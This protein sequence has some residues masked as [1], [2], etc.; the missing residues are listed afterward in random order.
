ME[1]LSPPSMPT[2]TG[3]V[4][5]CMSIFLLAYE[6]YLLVNKKEPISVAVYRF[7]QHSMAVVFIIGFLMGH[8]FW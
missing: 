2:T 7:G 1:H 5:I 3:I 8:F 6:I 4:L